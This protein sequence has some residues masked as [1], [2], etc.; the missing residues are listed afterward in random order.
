MKLANATNFLKELLENYTAAKKNLKIL[1]K[2]KKDSEAKIIELQN[3]MKLLE[4]RTQ[5]IPDLRKEI[6]E[7]NNILKRKNEELDSLKETF[8]SKIYQIKDLKTEILDKDE[9]ISELNSTLK[10]NN[11]RMEALNE[12]FDSKIHQIKELKTLLLSKEEIIENKTH[13]IKQLKF[14]MSMM[15]KKTPERSTSEDLIEKIEEVLK[16]KGFLSEKELEML[17]SGKTI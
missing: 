10:K 7:Q 2:E 1:K 11:E 17:K 5:T 3:S 15:D 12:T 8:E 16:L 14:Q 13:K 4:E 6:E 9:E